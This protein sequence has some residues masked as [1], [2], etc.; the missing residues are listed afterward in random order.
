MYNHDKHVLYIY[1]YIYIGVPI[2]RQVSI[3]IFSILGTGFS[4]TLFM[5]EILGRP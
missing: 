3:A 2:I 5:E 4:L 1:I